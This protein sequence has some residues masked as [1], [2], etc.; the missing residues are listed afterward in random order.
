MKT[1][2]PDRVRT[3]NSACF[4]KH[5]VTKV[6]KRIHYK[7]YRTNPGATPNYV[8]AY[9]EPMGVERI[10]RATADLEEDGIKKV[11]AARML[12]YGYQPHVIAEMEGLKLTKLRDWIGKDEEFKLICKDLQNDFMGAIEKKYQS[13]LYKAYE[14]LEVLMDTQT[15]ADI[16]W[17][18]DKTLEIH[19]KYVERV[20]DMTPADRKMPLMNPEQAIDFLDKGIKFLEL[21]RKKPEPLQVEGRVVEMEAAKCSNLD[22]K[23][24]S[25]EIDT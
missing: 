13:I 21:T 25:A 9:V 10:P 7:G 18:I 2:S 24:N 1:F 23:C 11:I 20:E 17:G 14:K 6:R 16:K 3:I 22:S 15:P 19:G 4:R 8:R 12:M 5:R